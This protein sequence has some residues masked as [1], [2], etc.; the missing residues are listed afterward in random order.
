M[1]IRYCGNVKMRVVC[2]DNG[3]LGREPWYRVTLSEEGK[4]LEAVEVRMSPDDARRWAVDNPEAIDSV[5][6]AA[7]SFSRADVQE[8]GQHKEDLSGWLIRR[9]A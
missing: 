3:G 5:A 4:H 2:E 1:A 6:H 8:L 7:M 9:R